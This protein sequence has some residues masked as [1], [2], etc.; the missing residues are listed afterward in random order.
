MIS[1]NTLLSHD[2][3]LNLYSLENTNEILA[4]SKKK[5]IFNFSNNVSDGKIGNFRQRKTGDCYLL[6][7]LV[8]L[9]KTTVGAEILK[10]NIKKDKAGGYRITLP[11]A[12]MCKN[13]YMKNGKKCYIT[14]EYHITKA[15]IQRARKQY[16]KYSSG[17][18]DVLL[19]EL[20]FEKYRKEVLKTNRAN[21]QN[22][23]Y[24]MA[25]QYTGNGTMN[26]PLKAGQTQDATFI[27]TGHKS[28]VY[29]ISSENVAAINS[30]D[31]KSINVQEEK[32]SQRATRKILEKMAKEPKRY[33]M[34]F[35]LKLDSGKPEY[36]YHALS[37]T[38]VEGN[39]VYFVNPWNSKKEFSL[40]KDEFFRA[41]Y[42]VTVT[43]FG[44]DDTLTNIGN[45]IENFMG[46]IEDFFRF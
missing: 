28:K 44:K 6:S 38:R 35:Y 41:A 27:L 16:D 19:Y 3:D 13:D 1:T 10:N 42:N 37:V 22:S 25:G 29:S 9:S 31:I 24:N 18:L 15:D 33:A 43:D 12:I 39:R 40:T 34:T 17:D 7:S 5:P 30:E 46:K 36:G 11:G 23:E 20:A 2:Y 4:T 26:D 8:A 32:I 45:G 14:G 21:N